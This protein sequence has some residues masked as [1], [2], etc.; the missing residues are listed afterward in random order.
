MAAERQDSLN[1]P[2]SAGG[3]GS[4]RRTTSWGGSPTASGA[5]FLATHPPPSSRYHKNS[6]P[7]MSITFSDLKVEEARL[8]M[9]TK[10]VRAWVA[11]VEVH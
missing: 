8:L 4:H 11:A 2:Q 1:V 3:G 9:T 5:P 6:K 10:L 7:E